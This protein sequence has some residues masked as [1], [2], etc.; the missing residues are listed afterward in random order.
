MTSNKYLAERGFGLAGQVSWGQILRLFPPEGKPHHSGSG[1]PFV[2]GA[3]MA[4]TMPMR[5]MAHMV[6]AA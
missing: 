4:V 1:W 2:S 6:I 5:K 3:K